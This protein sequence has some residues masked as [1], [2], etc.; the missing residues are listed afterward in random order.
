[1]GGD[2]LNQGVLQILFNMVI[3]RILVSTFKFSLPICRS[4]NFKSSWSQVT[5]ISG[6]NWMG[7]VMFQSQLHIL[8]TNI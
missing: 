1:M 3:L 4:D 6:W 7:P 5:I 2:L 8:E